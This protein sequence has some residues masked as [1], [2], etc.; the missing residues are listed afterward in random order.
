MRHH[1]SLITTT[2]ARAEEIEWL[3]DQDYDPVLA[4]E[5]EIRKKQ[6]EAYLDPP[7]RRPEPRTD[8][9]LSYKLTEILANERWGI[10][11][12]VGRNRPSR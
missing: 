7:A 4:R 10:D 3:L 8:P 11:R 9:N 5:L 12:K 2:L 6:L 1:H